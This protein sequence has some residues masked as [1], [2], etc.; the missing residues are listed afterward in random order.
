LSNFCLKIQAA[1][2]NDHHHPSPSTTTTT[3]NGTTTK[4]I[5]NKTINGSSSA[6]NNGQD[7]SASIEETTPSAE[8]DDGG[9]NFATRPCQLALS[10]IK[11]I[12][13]TDPELN[14]TSKESV[15]MIAKAAELFIEFF[16][17]EAYKITCQGTRKT[18][19]R[20][21]LDLAINS[22][23]QLCFLDAALD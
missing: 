7:D 5:S 20:K 16:S 1:K 8:N 21:D 17:K 12:M 23:D 14:L 2:S 9:D 22:V 6:I 11:S 18:V 15:F 4:Q 19:Q 13:K 3:T 10:R